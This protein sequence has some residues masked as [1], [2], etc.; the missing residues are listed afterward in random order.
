MNLLIV[1]R[2]PAMKLAH[3]HHPRKYFIYES[4]IFKIN[5]N[6]QKRMKDMVKQPISSLE[7]IRMSN[8]MKEMR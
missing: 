4:V 7:L 3:H 5:I 2:H 6:T 8:E 1:Y